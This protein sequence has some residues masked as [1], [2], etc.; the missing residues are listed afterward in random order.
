M[1]S[2]ISQDEFEEM[3]LRMNRRVVLRF[4]LSFLILL[5]LFT[6]FKI[7]GSF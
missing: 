4:F 1:G 5:I 2:Y 6:L 7:L 3:A